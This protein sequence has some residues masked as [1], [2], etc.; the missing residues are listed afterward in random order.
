MRYHL[1]MAWGFPRAQR[2]FAPALSGIGRR[3]GGWSH[4]VLHPSHT[5][6]HMHLPHPGPRVPPCSPARPEARV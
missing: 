1:S 6:S 4:G 3:E 2:T 5:C